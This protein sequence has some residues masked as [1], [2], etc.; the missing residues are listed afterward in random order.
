MKKIV[1]AILMLISVVGYS[2]FDGRGHFI[3]DTLSLTGNSGI[4][5]DTIT[6]IDA[7]FIYKTGN[8][9][10]EDTCFINGN[11]FITIAYIDTRTGGEAITQG[12]LLDMYL[13]N[14]DIHLQDN[15]DSINPIPQY[16]TTKRVYV[17]QQVD[18]MRLRYFDFPV[19][20]REMTITASDYAVAPLSKFY[21]D[22]TGL[23]AQELSNGVMIPAYNH[24]G[25]KYLPVNFTKSDLTKSYKVYTALLTN[26]DATPVS[27]GSL[28]V[29]ERYWVDSVLTHD[30]FTN[31][32]LDT[33]GMH[34]LGKYFRAT[35]VTPNTWSYGT[36]ITPIDTLWARELENTIGQITYVD[37]MMSGNTALYSAGGLFT[38]NKTFV[39]IG[40]Q[41]PDI[42]TANGLIIYYTYQDVQTIMLEGWDENRSNKY[43]QS[44]IPVYYYNFPIEIRVYK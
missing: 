40:N 19:T 36:I 27:S 33:L 29:G 22:P 26:V 14:V 10:C 1:F 39:Y 8:I 41:H 2:Q 15:Y 13:Y 35:G 30:D 3:T 20:K 24:S 28:I 23:Y 34:K 5:S 21:S 25:T 7:Y 38:E 17:G 37:V 16:V 31:V 32:G 4:C 12:G 11:Y 43:F 9:P 6:P 42:F 44:G 18:S